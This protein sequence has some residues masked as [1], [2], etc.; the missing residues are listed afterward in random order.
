[1]TLPASDTRYIAERGFP[2]EVSL[3]DGMTCVFLP[4]WPLP[5]GYNRTSANLLIRLQAGYPDVPPDM[6]WFEPI[7]LFANG[8]EIPAT[9]VREQH[10]GRIWQRWSRHLA[11]G[12]WRAGIDG[13]EA[14]LALVC[15]DLSSHVEGRTQ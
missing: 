8:S 10:L 3:E 12:Q 14:Y 7:V 5:P 11:A 9:Q 1:M 13:L 4:D 15:T 2:H 6:W